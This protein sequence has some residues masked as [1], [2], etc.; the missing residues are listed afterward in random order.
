MKP[1]VLLHLTHHIHNVMRDLWVASIWGRSWRWWWW[2]TV[3]ENVLEFW[4]DWKVMV[5]PCVLV[6][7]NIRSHSRWWRKWS[8]EFRRCWKYWNPRTRWVPHRMRWRIETSKKKLEK[9]LSMNRVR[10]EIDYDVEI[11]WRQWYARCN[12]QSIIIIICIF[13]IL[14]FTLSGI[15]QNYTIQMFIWKHATLYPGFFLGGGQR[16]A[17]RAPPGGPGA[18]PPAGV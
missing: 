17:K 1:W 13:I 8:G 9:I 11:C 2:C 3:N 5:L 14:Q 6:A 18:E 7:P 10:L 12:D 4:L 15:R 16:R